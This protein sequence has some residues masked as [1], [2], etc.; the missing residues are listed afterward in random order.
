[1][2]NQK[3]KR[4]MPLTYKQQS[5]FF[6]AIYHISLDFSCR[7]HLATIRLILEM[8]VIVL[9]KANTKCHLSWVGAVLSHLGSLKTRKRDK[10]CT[11]EGTKR[12]KDR[13]KLALVSEM[14]LACNS[15]SGE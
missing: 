12:V 4:L 7:D 11:K 6:L 10:M 1:M 5:N 9:V 15:A 8:I 13:K 2:Q 3:R 14:A